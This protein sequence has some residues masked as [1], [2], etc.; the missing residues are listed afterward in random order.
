M[1][2]SYIVALEKARFYDRYRYLPEATTY[3]SEE[4]PFSTSIHL[5]NNLVEV[6][7]DENNQVSYFN[8]VS[9][10]TPLSTQ[11]QV[12]CIGV[13][14]ALEVL[15]FASFGTFIRNVKTGVVIGVFKN[16]ST[17]SF[18]KRPNPPTMLGRIE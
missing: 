15:L 17:V 3:I 18:N 10:Y 5:P 13:L 9:A 11:I 4:R 14:Y 6:I 12:I 8:T 2:E 7:I 1:K 16:R